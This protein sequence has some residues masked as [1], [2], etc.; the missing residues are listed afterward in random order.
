MTVFSYFRLSS[1]GLETIWGNI[2]KPSSF[3]Q[4]FYI[5]LIS[6]RKNFLDG[7]FSPKYLLE[8]AKI[9]RNNIFQSFSRA[10]ELFREIP[11]NQSF[12][13]CSTACIF[14]TE[15]KRSSVQ[16]MYWKMQNS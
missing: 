5:T 12:G 4:M 10:F 13:N 7:I 11:K 9:Y 6:Y 2:E 14:P 1:G 3:Q 16:N 8:K 15:K